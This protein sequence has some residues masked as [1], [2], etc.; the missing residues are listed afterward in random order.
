[1]MKYCTK[2]GAKLVDGAKFCTV[3]GNRIGTSVPAENV[4]AIPVRRDPVQS[5]PEPYEAPAVKVKKR[6]RW[7]IL[8]MIFATVAALAV[9][10][11]LLI[12]RLFV[13]APKKFVEL[14]KSIISPVVDI[15]VKSLAGDIQS[16]LPEKTG[17]YSGIDTDLT[18]TAEIET[19]DGM[20]DKIIKESSVTLKVN[21]SDAE[22]PLFG[23]LLNLSGSDILSGTI[24][25]EK[26]KLGIYLPELSDDYY[27]IRFEDLDGILSSLGID[28]E[29]DFEDL[30]SYADNKKSPLGADSEKLADIIES[31]LDV[32]FSMVN[33]ENTTSSKEKLQLP[34]CGE[35]V[36][37]TVITFQPSAE[38]IS[39]MVK[40]LC[41][42]LKE[43]GELREIVKNMAEYVYIANP[44]FARQYA[45]SDDYVEYVLKSYD[46]AVRNLWTDNKEEIRSFARDLENREVCWKVAYKG[47]RIHM[48][49]ITDEDDNGIAYESVGNILE[50][51]T[52]MIVRLDGGNP[53]TYA[54]SSLK[55]KGKI[56]EGEV[57]VYRLE[58]GTAVYGFS[59]DLAKKSGLNIP[60]GEFSLKYGKNKLNMNVGSEET[61]SV[62]DFKLRTEDNTIK[63]RILST[64]E[65]STVMEPDG[66]AT[67]VTSQNIMGILMGIYGKLSEIAMNLF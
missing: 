62:H 48:I 26:D 58:D 35:T 13:N 15:S 50:R 18:V 11:V 14:H 20:I 52:D 7:G 40:Q 42:K 46:D 19:G 1:M 2:C 25:A 33:K 28:S 64:D 3:C 63:I 56:A 53:E 29:V 6:T 43:D 65:P 51:R 47:L 49:S 59:A 67:R 54:E 34:G 55:V 41:D 36:R 44:N 27:Q 39:E 30:L 31:Y 24:V 4:Q 12:P 60:Y 9:T 32:F 61:G 45:S 66:P 21:Q 23:F 8:A 22:R 5:D 10:A 17:N 16:V 37:C 57:R 38:E